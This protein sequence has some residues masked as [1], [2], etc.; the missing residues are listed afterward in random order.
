MPDGNVLW[1]SS[2]SSSRAA[3]RRQRSLSGYQGNAQAATS[4]PAASA[5]TWLLADEPRLRKP[6]RYCWCQRIWA[7]ASSL[8]SNSAVTGGQSSSRRR[9]QAKL[10]RRMPISM[11][12]VQCTPDRN[13][14]S[15]HHERSWAATRSA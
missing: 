10:I 8:C 5:I 2:C 14:L 15:C 7:T 6:A 1:S 13:G 12:L 3:A 11:P 4:W 9:I